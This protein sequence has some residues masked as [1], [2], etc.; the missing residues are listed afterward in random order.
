MALLGIGRALPCLLL[1]PK[2]SATSLSLRASLDRQVRRMC[3]AARS[4]EAITR[5][6]ATAS[7]KLGAVRVPSRRS[8]AI[9]QRAQRWY[10]GANRP[11]R[12]RLQSTDTNSEALFC[13]RVPPWCR[14]SVSTAVVW[15]FVYGARRPTIRSAAGRVKRVDGS[16]MVA[17]IQ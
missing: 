5:C 3:S 10:M 15:R 2:S 4:I 6:T 17:A 14:R 7:S 16:G 11:T 12:A 13:H 8:R 1:L 9:G